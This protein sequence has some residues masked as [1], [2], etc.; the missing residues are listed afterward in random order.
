MVL[1]SKGCS[2]IRKHLNSHLHPLSPKTPL[3]IFRL[4]NHGQILLFSVTEKKSWMNFSSS[5]R[6][7]VWHLH[8]QRFAW[9]RVWHLSEE[10]K[11]H[12]FGLLVKLG[13]WCFRNPARKPPFGCKTLV[14]FGIYIYISTGARFLPWT[15]L[16]MDLLTFFLFFGNHYFCTTCFLQMGWSMLKPFVKRGYYIVLVIE[17]QKHQRQC[18]CNRQIFGV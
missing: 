10:Q 7:K 18:R 4:P 11:G 1:G 15:V 12:Q 17:V 6:Y 8:I 5:S 9:S 2:L 3:K 16:K 14:N 13:C